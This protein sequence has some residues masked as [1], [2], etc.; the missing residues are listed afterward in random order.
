MWPGYEDD[1]DGGEDHEHGEDDGDGE[2]PHPG[3]DGALAVLFGD[4]LRTPAE[5]LVHR[6]LPIV[7]Y[8]DGEPIPNLA[9][10]PREG[11]RAALA[12]LRRHTRQLSRAT[13]VTVDDARVAGILVGD[14]MSDDPGTRTF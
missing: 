11:W 2:D 1:D 4:T 14:L 8:N 5:P 9:R 7:G 10:I 3:D 6:G 13:V 12:P